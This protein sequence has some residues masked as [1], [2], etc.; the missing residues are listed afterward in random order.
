MFTTKFTE[1][2]YTKKELKELKLTHTLYKIADD[3]LERQRKK[4]N[5]NYFTELYARN[6]ALADLKKAVLL[7]CPQCNEAQRLDDFIDLYDCF[8]E[9][10]ICYECSKQGPDLTDALMEHLSDL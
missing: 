3:E 9:G 1:D 4:N 5:P 2:I 10:R 7:V 8:R 6:R